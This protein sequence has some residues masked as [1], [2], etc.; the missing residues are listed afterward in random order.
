MDNIVAPTISRDLAS[1]SSQQPESDFSL[2]PLKRAIDDAPPENQEP[3]AKKAAV[4][5]PGSNK[6]L[7][8]A[9]VMMPSSMRRS[10]EYVCLRPNLGGVRRLL[11]FVDRYFAPDIK[12]E[13][14]VEFSTTL[15]QA[16]Y[17]NLD[18]ELHKCEIKRGVSG[19]EMRTL[20]NLPYALAYAISTL[21]DDVPSNK[22]ERPIF[23]ISREYVRQHAGDYFLDGAGAEL[24]LAARWRVYISLLMRHGHK[25]NSFAS[26]ATS[27]QS[28]IRT[29]AFRSEIDGVAYY[30]VVSRWQLSRTQELFAGLLRLRPFAPYSYIDGVRLPVTF[31]PMLIDSERRGLPHMAADFVSSSEFADSSFI[32]EILLSFGRRA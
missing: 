5:H 28:L 30:H 17:Y 3:P 13:E 29:G 7:A 1:A 19:V 27:V 21:L 11:D 18:I 23:Y 2:S 14:R 24:D 15:R 20:L 10:T 26:K 31:E 12:T 4:K 9:Q 16:F 8:N 6:P 25:V 22:E 32:N